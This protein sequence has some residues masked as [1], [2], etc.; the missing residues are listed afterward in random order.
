MSIH[1]NTPPEILWPVRSMV[2]RI[3]LDP[4][5]NETSVVDAEHTFTQPTFDGLLQLWAANTPKGRACFVNPPY[6]RDYNDKWAAKWSDEAT[7]S[8][9]RGV[10]LF[11]LVQA[12]PGTKW[13]HQYMLSCDA[14]CFPNARIA[15]LRD[16]APVKG[17]NFGNALFYAGPDRERFATQMEFTGGILFR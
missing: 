15:F 10:H 17:A 6:G 5:S 14:V 11:A 4:C 12:S 16:G 2:G 3:Y 8:R 1:W 13:F 9:D 7:D